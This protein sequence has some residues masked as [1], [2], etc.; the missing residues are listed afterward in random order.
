ML[1]INGRKRTG[2]A[3]ATVDL[4][5]LI[6]LFILSVYAI[7]DVG[8]LAVYK[9][10]LSN[11][12]IMAASYATE[13]SVDEDIA[14]ETQRM[15]LEMAKRSALP[16]SNLKISTKFDT[17]K[18][19]ELVEVEIEGE[20][21]LLV[22]YNLPTKVKLLEKAC[23]PMPANRVHAVLG[24]SPYPYAQESDAAKPCVYIPIVR[25]SHSLPVWT[26]PFDTSLNYLRVIQGAEPDFSRKKDSQT[27]LDRPSIY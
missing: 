8:L 9:F 22:G 18:E 20:F 6:P 16:S 19:A 13:L 5:I 21:P 14:G 4:V 15:S 3:L 23:A 12:A 2:M 11:I 26:F 10:K 7:C 17:T 27:F 25:P 24:I 1:I